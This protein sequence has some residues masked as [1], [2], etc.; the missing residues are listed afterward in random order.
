[1]AMLPVVVVMREPSSFHPHSFIG[2]FNAIDSL[3]MRKAMGGSV[4]R[5]SIGIE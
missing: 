4:L 3:I 5:G 2:I 1:M